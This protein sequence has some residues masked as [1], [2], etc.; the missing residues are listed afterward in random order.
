MS[1]RDNAEGTRVH[2]KSRRCR[3]AE[4]LSCAFTLISSF[5]FRFIRCLNVVIIVEHSK[6]LSCK[7]K[8]FAKQSVD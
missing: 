2:V 6:V 3:Q 7:V 1:A 8:M 5:G 4:A